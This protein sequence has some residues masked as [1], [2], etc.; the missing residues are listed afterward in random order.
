[1]ERKNIESSMINSIGYEIESATLEIEFNSGVIWQYFDFSEA[2]WYEF[3][4]S[5]SHGKHFHR[6]IKGQYPEAQ[7]G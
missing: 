1:M 3:E 5:E 6:E 2:S 4:N 7:V